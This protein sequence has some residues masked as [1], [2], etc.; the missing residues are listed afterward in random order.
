MKSV[1]AAAI[2]GNKQDLDALRKNLERNGKIPDGQYGDKLWE[3]AESR[4][5]VLLQ[6]MENVPDSPVSDAGH[7]TF[8]DKIELPVVQPDGTR[9]TLLGTLDWCNS[10]HN[11]ITSITTSEMKGKAGN[12]QFR[13]SKYTGPYVAALA[14][15]AQKDSNEAE[16]VDISIYSTRGNEPS[17]AKVR[18]TPEEARTTLSALY[19]KAFQQKYSKAVPIDMVDETITSFFEY[20]QKLNNAWAYFDKRHLLD[21]RKDTGFDPQNDFNGELG[22]WS[23]EAKKQKDL[24]RIEIGAPQNTE[25]EE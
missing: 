4:K 5:N 12:K 24:F 21:K 18:M 6:Q 25:G 2:T 20:S 10:E 1:V 16:T 23:A 8:K 22:A 19:D 11:S 7:W 9:W 15:I 3:V 14:L 13:N 17:K